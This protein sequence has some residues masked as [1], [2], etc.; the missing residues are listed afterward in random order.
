M[1]GRSGKRT[2]PNKPTQ[3]ISG[4]KQ[5]AAHATLPTIFAP[6]ARRPLASDEAAGRRAWDS[7]PAIGMTWQ[8]RAA[9]G[10]DVLLH[11]TCEISFLIADDRALSPADCRAA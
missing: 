1:N 11:M 6:R 9:F 3:K 5:T 10:G 2:N 7:A 8:Y 4:G